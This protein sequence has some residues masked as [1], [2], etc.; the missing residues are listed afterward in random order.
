[1]C[2]NGIGELAEEKEKLVHDVAMMYENPEMEIYKRLIYVC[3][4]ASV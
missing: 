3:D 4:A 2:K 1:M